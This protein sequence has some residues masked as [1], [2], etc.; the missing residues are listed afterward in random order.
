MTPT[1]N[2]LTNDTEF[3]RQAKL[4]YGLIVAG[5]SANFADKALKAFLSRLTDWL[6]YNQSTRK[7]L[8][9]DMLRLLTKEAIDSALH[10]SKTGNY[11]K[12]NKAIADIRE[13][14]DLDLRTVIPEQLEKIHGCGP[15]TSRFVICWIRPEEP[16]AILD[17]HVLR[18][19]ASLGYTV[20]RQTPQNPKLYACIEKMFLDEAAKRGKT[21]REL[22]ME[23]WEA[24][25]GRIQEKAI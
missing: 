4:L 23:I 20:P 6:R 15:K 19:M 16:Y 10:I 2:I 8:P 5:K 24:G 25:A 18:W 14:R 9:L 21:P 22:D 3:D 13:M 17:V 7:T 12:L 1:P 11:V